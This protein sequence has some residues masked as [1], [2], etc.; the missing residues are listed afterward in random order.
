MPATRDFFEIPGYGR[1]DPPHLDK[2]PS[3]PAD[4]SKGKL[5]KSSAIYRTQRESSNQS[6][7]IASE[8]FATILIVR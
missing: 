7:L 5:V 4:I 8:G 3:L 1:L 6:A 2:R